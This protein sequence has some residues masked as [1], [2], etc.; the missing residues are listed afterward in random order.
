M[1]KTRN[2]YAAPLSSAV[3]RTS[4]QTNMT[5]CQY[6]FSYKL[7]HTMGNVDIKAEL[8]CKHWILI[9]WGGT[10]RSLVEVY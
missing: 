4:L 5:T 6:S 9:F 2:L 3:R 10:L 7:P 1:E 8:S